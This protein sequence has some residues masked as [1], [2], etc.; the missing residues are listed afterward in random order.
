MFHQEAFDE[1]LM[2]FEIVLN[3]F[4]KSITPKAIQG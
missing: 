4:F 3:I 1:L 2:A